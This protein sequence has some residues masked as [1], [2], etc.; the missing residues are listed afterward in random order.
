M[1]S[2]TR[3]L[4]IFALL[5]LAVPVVRADNEEPVRGVA[6]EGSVE[7]TAGMVIFPVSQ[8]GRLQVRD[9]GNCGHAVVQLDAR[10]Q[11]NLLGQLVSLREMADY[12]TRNPGVALTIHYRLKDSI[13]S[14]VSVLGK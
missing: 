9:C 13:A 12:A 10:T 4:G 5:A 7:T 14:R 6:L 3:V 1:N 2:Y 8:D 11:Y